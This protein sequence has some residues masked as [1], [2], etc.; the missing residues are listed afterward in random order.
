MMLPVPRSRM[1]KWAGATRRS[2]VRAAQA[3][4][5][6]FADLLAAPRCLLC[7]VRLP[8]D[9]PPW[10]LCARCESRVGYFDWEYCPVCGGAAEG[11]YVR[12]DGCRWCR[13][14]RWA[15]ERVVAL[16]PYERE[17][18][19]A[20]LKTK[21]P[22]GERLAR[23]LAELFCEVRQAELESLG[24]EVVLP[25]PM[26]WGRRFRRAANAPEALA[27]VIARRLGL[28]WSA[29]AIVRSRHTRLQS[30][31][32]PRLRFRNVRGAFRVTD[33]GFVSR[34]RV[35]VVDD[36]LTTGATCHELARTL[37]EAGAA[38][39]VVAVLARAEGD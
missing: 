10:R 33:A 30:E 22:V 20:V 3:G 35:L 26:F 2:A 36:I 23:A 9:A 4:L 16:G 21:E 31:M 17:L 1:R 11:N 14:Q 12:D 29:D 19:E 27:E 25:V 15:F 34:R 28:D 32:R 13:D 7:R 6:R 37:C 24:A 38:S 5:E 8:P 18:R 39:V